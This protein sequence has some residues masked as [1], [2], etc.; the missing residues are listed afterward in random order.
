MSLTFDCYRARLSAIPRAVH[1]RW[2]CLCALLYQ[3][4]PITCETHRHLLHSLMCHPIP[5]TSSST[6]SSPNFQL[7]FN[8][9]LDA[10]KKRTKNDLLAH[11]LVAQLQDCKSHSAILAVIHQQFQQFHQSQEGGERLTKWLDP[12]VKVLYSLSETLG[13]GVSLVCLIESN[14]R[15][16]THSYP[17]ARCSI[18]R[19]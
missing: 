8:N 5:S 6:S 7:I 4:I 13:E 9:A 2:Q 11:P 19:K 17:F 15:I 3:L 14:R 16:F 10:Y 1:R 12:T 18:P